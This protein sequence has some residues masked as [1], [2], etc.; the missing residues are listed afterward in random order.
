MTFVN[1]KGT[2][3]K[4]NMKPLSEKIRELRLARGMSLREMSAELS[5]LGQTVSHTAIARWE[6]PGNAAHLP[7]RKTVFA[8]AELFNV[9]VGW[10]LADLFDPSEGDKPI[11]TRRQMFNDIDALGD[12]EFKALLAVKDELVR[13]RR[14]ITNA[15]DPAGDK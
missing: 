5:R 12:A 7:Q 14:Q 6:K 13:M 11:T 15:K 3:K 9:S 1:Q 8:I 4:K 10:L 2:L